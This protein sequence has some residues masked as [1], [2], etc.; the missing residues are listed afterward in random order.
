MGLF[1]LNLNLF[2]LLTY[3]NY[4]FCTK[5]DTKITSFDV[6]LYIKR[7]YYR[8]TWYRNKATHNLFTDVFC[9]HNL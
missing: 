2:S 6:I 9:L 1:V 7:S 8:T 3:G 5:N 4:Y